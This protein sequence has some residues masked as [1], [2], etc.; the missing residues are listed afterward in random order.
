M[1]SV[2]FEIVRRAELFSDLTE[3]E[4]KELLNIVEWVALHPGQVLFEQ[5]F[6][7]MRWQMKTPENSRFAR[8][9]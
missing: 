5:N 6:V 2:L 3:D 8:K 7:I 1:D 4:L 9:K